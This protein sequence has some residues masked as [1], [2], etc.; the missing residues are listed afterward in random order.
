MR[1]NYIILL[2][3]PLLA[4]CASTPKNYGDAPGFVNGKPIHPTVKIGSPYTLKGE[5][6][7]PHY[8]PYYSQT[9]EASW[10]GPGFHGEK[11]ANG[12]QYNQYAFTAAHRTLPLPSMIR[13][14]NLANG[15]SVIVRVNDR[16]PFANDR[17]LDVSKAAAQELDMIRSGVAKVKIEY[18]KRETEAYIAQ[19]SGT[20]SQAQRAWE[21]KNLTYDTASKTDRTSDGSWF[22]VIIPSAHAESA[23]NSSDSRN[24]SASKPVN[25]RDVI[26]SSDL[27][28]IQTAS[29]QAELPE[30]IVVSDKMPPQPLPDNHSQSTA[31]VARQ[32]SE[33]FAPVA[34]NSVES[35]AYSP[36]DVLEPDKHKTVSVAT[37]TPNTTAPPQILD[38]STYRSH[39]PPLSKQKPR[40]NRGAI[41][42]PAKTGLFIQV[43]AFSSKENALKIKS[44]FDKV[45]HTSVQG[46]PP[47]I[48]SLYRVRL[49]PFDSRYQAESVLVQ[50]RENGAPDAQL[51][52]LD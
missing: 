5:T 11:T 28:P 44:R 33:S 23:P 14:T 26:A 6:Y 41:D 20:K 48:P 35:Y 12:E 19:L 24:I 2:L 52:K 51:L 8:D 40:V 3:L 47:D 27:P 31:N 49:G 1:R 16:G 25:Q 34:N 36:Y 29:N 43:G 45:A 38:K 42:T 4:A 18:L 39:G 30:K 32:T 50:V 37:V 7:R 46:V 10:Y 21:E 15:K 13:V 17:I 9:G 22:D